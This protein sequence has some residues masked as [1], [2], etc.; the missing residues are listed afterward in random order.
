[1]ISSAAEEREDEDGWEDT[2]TQESKD[3]GSVYA[4]G[5]IW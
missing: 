5:M 3:K 1:M 2:S 4:L